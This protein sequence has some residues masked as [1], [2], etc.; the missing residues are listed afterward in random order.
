MPSFIAW[1]NSVIRDTEAMRTTHLRDKEGKE[2]FE[3]DVL[4]YEYNEFYG[5]VTAIVCWDESKAAFTE[6]GRFSSGGGWESLNAEHFFK[7]KKLGSVH[8]FPKML[9]PAK[10]QS[11]VNTE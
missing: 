7:Y 4:S 6:Q 5:N 3:G 8:T 1:K 10:L 2:I 11:L 9:K